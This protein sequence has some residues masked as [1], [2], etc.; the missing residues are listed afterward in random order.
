MVKIRDTFDPD[1]P[2][3]GTAPQTSVNMKTPIAMGIFM[4]T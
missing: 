4:P 2:H 1:K 3:G